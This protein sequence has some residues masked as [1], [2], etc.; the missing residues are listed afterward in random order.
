MS[1][2]QDAEGLRFAFNP[3]FYLTGAVTNGVL[4]NSYSIRI[5]PGITLF[6]E[7]RQ[8]DGPSYRVAPSLRFQTPPM[9]HTGHRA[10]GPAKSEI[11]RACR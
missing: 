10:A 1:P 2:D 4:E 9:T 8:Y 7:W 3:H 11:H 5:E 6:N